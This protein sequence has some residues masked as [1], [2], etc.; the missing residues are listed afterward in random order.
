MNFEI[1]EPNSIGLQ[2]RKY[3]EIIDARSIADWASILGIEFFDNSDLLPTFFI[4]CDPSEWWY[5]VGRATS[6]HF[7]VKKLIVVVEMDNRESAGIR[8]SDIK[9]MYHF[10]FLRLLIENE[11][12]R[13]SSLTVR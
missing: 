13:S 5:K 4:H 1:Y 12:G 10:G 3:K 9:G 11:F 7:N 6:M 8:V 2:C